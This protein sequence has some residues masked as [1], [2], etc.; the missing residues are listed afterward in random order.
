M[1]NILKVAVFV[2]VIAMVAMPSFA[3]TESVGYSA[4]VAI[5]QSTSATINNNNF[6]TMLVNTEKTITNSLTLTNSG[7]INATVDTKFTSFAG[8]T[9]GLTNSTNVI[10]ASNFSLKNSTDSTWYALNNDGSDKLG[11][12]IVPVSPPRI[13]DARL[14]VPLGTAAGAY[15]GTVLL[16]FGNVP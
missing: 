2:M 13:L 12:T 4:T 3:S 7:D 1:I 6:G 15:T 9:Y 8:T 11:I 16:T 10:G 5:G 14:N